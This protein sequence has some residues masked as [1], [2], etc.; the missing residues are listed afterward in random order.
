[1]ARDT[2]ARITSN[3]LTQEQQDLLDAYIL[4]LDDKYE[5]LKLAEKIQVEIETAHLK[6]ILSR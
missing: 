4:K 3:I 2:E 5:D 6:R 1:M